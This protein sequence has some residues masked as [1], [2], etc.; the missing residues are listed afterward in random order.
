M[1]T[2]INGWGK[3]VPEL[4]QDDLF[5]RTGREVGHQGTL[6]IYRFGCISS[7]DCV[8]TWVEADFFIVPKSLLG[9]AESKCLDFH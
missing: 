4:Q 6:R 3:K 7:G 9:Q 2:Y 8:L 1:T 5:V